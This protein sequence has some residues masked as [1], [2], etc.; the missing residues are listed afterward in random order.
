M[1]GHGGLIVN[2]SNTDCDHELTAQ[3]RTKKLP[4]SPSANAV[5]NVLINEALLV[6]S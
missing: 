5:Q 4:Q 6:Y 1:H 2:F 3:L